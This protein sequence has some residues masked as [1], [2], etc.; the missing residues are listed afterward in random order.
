MALLRGYITVS[1]GRCVLTFR[2]FTLP[3][4]TLNS[5]GAALI[6]V[7]SGSR[8][9]CAITHSGTALYVGF[10]ELIHVR[11]QTSGSASTW[12]CKI[13][14]TKHHDVSQWRPGC[15]HSCSMCLWRVVNTSGASSEPAVC[16]VAFAI[17]VVFGSGGGADDRSKGNRHIYC[18]L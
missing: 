12:R 5:G 10:L 2:R 15:F 11:W 4:F 14:M 13:A 18:C 9:Y 6:A 16:L 3:A 7:H 1:S 8:L 17:M